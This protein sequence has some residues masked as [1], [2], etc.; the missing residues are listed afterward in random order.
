MTRMLWMVATVALLVSL[1][2]PW[3]HDWGGQSR[4]GAAVLFAVDDF[5]PHLG[6]LLLGLWGV[7]G[8]V[9]RSVAGLSAALLCS[10]YYGVV[11]TRDRGWAFGVDQ[12][13][14]DVE[15]V[16]QGRAAGGFYLAVAAS[17]LLAG[18]VLHDQGGRRRV[19]ADVDDGH[20][21]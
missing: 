15:W 4:T 5:R 9:R 2:L 21:D 11:I 12:A 14:R 13:G 10:A 8:F 16:M 20:G 18:G 6:V 19:A 1:A 7:A 17:V 3:V